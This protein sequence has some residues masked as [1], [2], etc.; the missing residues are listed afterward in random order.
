MSLVI[1]FVPK[2]FDKEKKYLTG[3]AVTELFSL[4]TSGVKT[5]DDKN[6]VAIN[7]KELENKLIELNVNFDSEKVFKYSYRPFDTGVIY[8]DTKLL[9]RA[10]EKTIYHLKYENIGLILVAQP[11]AA[12][13]NYFDCL[14][15][16]NCLTDT[17]MYRRGGPLSFPLYLYHKNN[18]QEKLEIDERRTPNLNSEKLNLIASKLELTFTNEK[19][20]TENTFAPIDVL[21]YIYAALHSPAYREKYQ[22]FLK[23]DFPRVPYPKDKE[24]FWKLVKLGGEIRQLHLLESS[25]V[26]NY[27]TSYPKDGDNSITTKIGIKDWELFD[28]K[29]KLGRIWINDQQY[30]DAIPLVAWEF[31]I[32]GY[33]PAQ[34]WLKDRKGRTL[35]YNDILHYQKMI[36]ALYETDRIMKEIDNI[37]F[38]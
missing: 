20:K 14:Y 27:I 35:D 11:Q 24:T 18:L 33:Q 23:I 5:H 6:L 4:R 1:F 13:L 26:E 3:F 28:E 15:L 12:N 7:S 17:N 21:D 10:R 9:G 2:N 16:T 22:E 30:F 32:G 34:K 25:T 36:V 37:K 29:N 31:Y 38:E 8:Y 19:E